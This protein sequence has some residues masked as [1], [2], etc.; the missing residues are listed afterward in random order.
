MPLVAQTAF[1]RV[2]AH[3]SFEAKALGNS[4]VAVG[5]RPKRAAICDD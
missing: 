4:F 1:L 3:V 5:F 2:L